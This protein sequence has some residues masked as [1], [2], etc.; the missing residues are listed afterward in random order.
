MKHDKLVQLNAS[1]NVH[2][3]PKGADEPGN[4]DQYSVYE[5][6]YVVVDFIENLRIGKIC[7]GI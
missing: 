2:G 7:H 6:H 1:H 5:L 4:W 3:G